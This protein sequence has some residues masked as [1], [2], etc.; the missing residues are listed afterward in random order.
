NMVTKSGGD[1]WQG[2]GTFAWQGSGTQSSNIDDNLLHFGFL[3]TTNKVDYVSDVNVSA[4]G[5]VIAKKLR[6]F[7]SFRDWRVHVNGP[8]AF[9]TTVLDQTNIDSGLV[10]ATYQLND[11]N[12]FTGFWSR[13]RYNKPNRFL[14]APTTILVKDSTSD[15]EDIFNVYQALWNAIVS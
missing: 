5:P 9:S 4:G 15:E 14:Q 6:V 12:K 10:N 11:K 3:P 1:K 13:Q 2:R 7:G 8:A